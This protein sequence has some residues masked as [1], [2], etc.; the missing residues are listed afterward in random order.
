MLCAQT[1]ATTISKI[2]AVR[3]EFHSDFEQLHVTFKFAHIDLKLY[4]L[5]LTGILEAVGNFG[6]SAQTIVNK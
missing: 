3:D 2:Y 6:K 5:N 4:E 1:A